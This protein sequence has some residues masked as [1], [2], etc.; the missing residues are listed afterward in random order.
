MSLPQFTFTILTVL[1][2]SADRILFKIAAGNFEFSAAGFTG[3]PFNMKL[4][5]TLIGCFLPRLGGFL[6]PNAA[7]GRPMLINISNLQQSRIFNPVF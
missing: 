4:I 5:V 6:C 7:A 1:T 2:L 3:S